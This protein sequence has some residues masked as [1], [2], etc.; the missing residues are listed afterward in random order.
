MIVIG[1]YYL[2]FYNKQIS[3]IE[4]FYSETEEKENEEKTEEKEEITEIKTIVVHIMGE[5]ENE[6]IVEINEG[7]RVS[8]AINAAGGLKETA[9]ISNINL[10]FVLEDGMKIIIPSKEDKT[11]NIN[12]NTE[13]I[14]TGG[15]E[16]IISGS[17]SKKENSLININTATQEELETLPGIGSAIALRIITYRE[18]NGKFSSIEDIKKVSGIGDSKFSNIKD[19]IC[20]Q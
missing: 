19:L 4:S 7:S 8:D 20:V 16:N 1:I 12:S 5:V 15:G 6:G 17:S 10:A 13:N 3:E 14:I 9:D 11:V 18:E 2:F